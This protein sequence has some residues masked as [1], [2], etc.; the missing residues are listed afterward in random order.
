ME[1]NSK[2]RWRLRHENYVTAVANL[3][4][5]LAEIDTPA[6]TLLVRDGLIKRYEIAYELAWNLLKD[7]LDYEAVQGAVGSRSTIRLAINRGLVQNGN[8]WM[9]MVD[10]RNLAAHAYSGTIASDLV[11]TIRDRYFSEL[12]KLADYFNTIET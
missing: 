12:Q 7:Y 3:L 6:Y 4:E 11:P 2:P 5:A 9:D 10:S 1:K 8:V